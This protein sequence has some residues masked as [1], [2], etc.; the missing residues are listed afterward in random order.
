MP[1][2]QKVSAVEL[3]FLEATL[4]ILTKRQPQGDN[5][6]PP[7]PPVSAYF[8]KLLDAETDVE[9]FRN[10]VRINLAI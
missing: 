1:E 2:R 9:Q 10:Y 5:A 4:S 3:V 6:K 8:F 7:S